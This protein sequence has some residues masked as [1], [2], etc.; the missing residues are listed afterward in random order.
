M[1][2]IL[3][4]VDIT[5]DGRYWA[6]PQN[7]MHV[8]Y[9]INANWYFAFFLLFICITYYVF[10]SVHNYFTMS[11]IYF[12]MGYAIAVMKLL[13]LKADIKYLRSLIED[14]S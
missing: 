4:E 13:L 9:Q 7:L 3:T 6:N 2:S 1:N 8:R 11:F 14:R 5:C 12:C 10:T